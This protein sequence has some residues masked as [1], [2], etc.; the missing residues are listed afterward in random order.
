[1]IRALPTET[2]VES[3]TSQSKSGT[4]VD[5]SNV[6]NPGPGCRTQE[7]GPVVHQPLQRYLAMVRSNLRPWIRLQN[8]DTASDQYRVQREAVENYLTLLQIC[9]ILPKNYKIRKQDKFWEN[10]DVDTK[11][12]AHLHVGPQVDLKSTKTQ[13]LDQAAEPR[14]GIGPKLPTADPSVL[15]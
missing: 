5:L 8:Q 11:V 4:S 12:D 9:L 3:G 2:K 15:S 10:P 1:M 7:P 13:A 6:G 14:H